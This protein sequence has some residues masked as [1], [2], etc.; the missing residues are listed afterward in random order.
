M[1]ALPQPRS[2]T[3]SESPLRCRLPELVDLGRRLEYRP[4]LGRF[5]RAFGERWLREGARVHVRL[6]AQAQEGGRLLVP[7]DW[8]LLTVWA[9]S[10][11]GMT[12]EATWGAPLATDWGEGEGLCSS[13]I[14]G[15]GSPEPPH[16]SALC[17]RPPGWPVGRWPL[18]ELN[19][20]LNPRLA[21]TIRFV[22]C[23]LVSHPVAVT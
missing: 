1:D 7:A 14:A 4:T 15:L 5:Y 11:S 23:R 17:H 22:R 8:S 10:P 16:R 2:D 19:L 6:V 18:G 9:P 13:S 3:S 20:L 12:R 21:I